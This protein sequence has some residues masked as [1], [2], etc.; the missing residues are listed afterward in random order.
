MVS[1]LR[2]S[3]DGLATVT[4]AEPAARALNSAPRH[5][6]PSSA[7]AW[8]RGLRARLRRPLTGRTGQPKT[9]GFA[10]VSIR[11]VTLWTSVGTRTAQFAHLVSV[12]KLVPNL[13]DVRK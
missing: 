13:T 3:L 7:D 12:P 10:G 8:G 9:P 6:Y 11:P 5:P 1:C 2:P 4:S